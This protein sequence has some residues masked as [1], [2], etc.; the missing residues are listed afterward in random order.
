MT[1]LAFALL[2]ALA[3]SPAFACD[4]TLFRQMAAPSV[5]EPDARLDVPEV[6]STEGGEWEVWLGPDRTTARELVRIDYGE[7]GRRVVRFFVST[8]GAYA[9]TDTNYIYSAPLPTEGSTTIREEKDIYIFCDGKLYLPEGDLGPGPA[10]AA[11]E[12]LAT[13]D[14]AEMKQYVQGLRR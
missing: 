12:A 3:A 7:G 1:R 8:P 14:A 2:L 5:G 6:A 9:V 13:F 10:Y 4:P 11:K